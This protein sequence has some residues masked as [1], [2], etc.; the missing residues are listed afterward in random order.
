MNK[1]SKLAN[2]AAQRKK[3]SIVRLYK[4]KINPVVF[5]WP[6]ESL[7]ILIFLTNIYPLIFIL[8][9]WLFILLSK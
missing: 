7:F 1:A 8:S 2:H 5:L 9:P 6:C 4:K 3:R